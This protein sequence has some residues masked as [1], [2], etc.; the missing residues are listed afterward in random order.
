MFEKCINYVTIQQVVLQKF[1]RP[2]SFGE[3]R[4]CPIHCSIVV[5]TEILCILVHIV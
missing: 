5:R 1:H 2:L 4:G 3:Y